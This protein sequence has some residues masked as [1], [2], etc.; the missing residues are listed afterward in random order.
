MVKNVTVATAQKEITVLETELH[1][2]RN[3]LADDS[4]ELEAMV[5]NNTGADDPFMEMENELAQFKSDLE[6]L[7]QQLVDESL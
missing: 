5:L 6:M 2:Q 3:V 7:R 4:G 1:Q